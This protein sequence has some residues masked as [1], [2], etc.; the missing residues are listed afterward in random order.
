MSALT[1]TAGYPV[2]AV[3]KYYEWTNEHGVLFVDW[4]AH[5]GA[6]GT[7]TGH[8]PF[9]MA[10]SARRAELCRVCFPGQ[11]HDAAVYPEPVRVYSPEALHG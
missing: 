3:K 5:C 2:H 1:I 4:L 8:R 9:G 6:K 11:R 10:G 7:L